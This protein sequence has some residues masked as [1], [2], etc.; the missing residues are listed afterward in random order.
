[1]GRG[2]GLRYAGGFHI[3]THTHTHT[4][5]HTHIYTHIYT[6]ARR[7]SPVQVCEGH[8]LALVVLQQVL[9]QH[10]EHLLRGGG[11]EG[12]GRGR[13]EGERSE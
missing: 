3:H 6:H 1:M 5:T 7:L 11:R 8:S 13:E 10:L 12:G 2:G 4:R 9:G